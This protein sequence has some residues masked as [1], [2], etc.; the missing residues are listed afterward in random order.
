M[1]EKNRLRFVVDDD[2]SEDKLRTLLHFAQEMKAELDELDFKGSFD[3][4]GTPDKVELAKDVV[5][6][7]NTRGGY[8]LLGVAND[9][10]PV[11]L[12]KE[13]YDNLDPTPLSNKV[14]EYAI[15]QEASLRLAKHELSF[16]S[17]EEP[18]YFGLLYCPRRRGLPIMMSKDGNYQDP[19]RPGHH[20]HAFRKH[21][22]YV[23][24]GAQSKPMQPEDMQRFFGEALAGSKES[25]MEDI[26][27]LMAESEKVGR[28]SQLAHE[29]LTAATL[30]IDSAAFWRILISLYR[31]HDTAGLLDLID[32]GTQLIDSKWN[33]GHSL[34]FEEAKKLVA[35]QLDI[36]LD[37]L[38]L[39][40][41]SATRLDNPAI[42]QESIGS[43]A[44][45]YSLRWGGEIVQG[46]PESTRVLLRR[47]APSAVMTRIYAI[48]GY[49][50]FKQR[51]ASI[52]DILGLPVITTGLGL[53]QKDLLVK[54][55][56]RYRYGEEAS[57]FFESAEQYLQE[58][59][60]LLGIMQQEK[61]DVLDWLCQFD[62][63]AGYVRWQQEEWI[64]LFYFRDA[65]LSAPIIELTLHK[66]DEILG[67]YY[68]AQSFADYLRAI[69][70]IG[71]RRFGA[72]HMWM[73]D[74]LPPDVQRF[75]HEHP[76]RE[77]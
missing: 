20:L 8:I 24:R 51:H 58:R 53:Q 55:P 60:T 47:W 6:M 21:D 37:K 75:L 5:A 38:T 7:N 1:E 19:N 46:V 43:L 16:E 54:H 2:L 3:M 34:S 74:R 66:P 50:I 10:T 40:A 52:L 45:V 23:R 28:A 14:N 27:K 65:R 67:P 70:A 63:L 35:G 72:V 56:E 17:V 49:A 29:E 36:V 44:R 9:G 61:R 71:R 73:L 13:Q 41:A 62:V 26:T 64:G 42:F 15:P 59:A 32:L 4:S 68:D 30:I 77:T 69:E 11:G 76:A 31:N 48:G 18:R 22:V 12:S 39:I 33:E 25:W 57:I